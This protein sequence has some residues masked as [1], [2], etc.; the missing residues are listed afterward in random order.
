MVVAAVVAVREVVGVGVVVSRLSV[1][2]EP[3]FQTSGG[4]ASACIPAPRREY[5]REIIL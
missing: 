1:R 2:P 3:V 5:F 4:S